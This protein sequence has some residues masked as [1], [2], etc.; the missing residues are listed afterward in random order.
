[1]CRSGGLAMSRLARSD[2]FDPDVVGIYHCT[3]RCVRRC[4]LQGID[5]CTGNN[6]DHRK[7]WIRDRLEFLAGCFGIDCLGYAILSNHLHLILRNRPDVI[8]EWSDA[9]VAKR[10]LMLCPLR[11]DS[12]GSPA[13]PTEAEIDSLCS[14][15][16]KIIELRR[17][18]GDISWMMRM[19]AEPIARR[20]N[21][22]D[23]CSGRF[24]EGRFHAVRLLDAIAVLACSIY[25]DLNP[26]RARTAQTP[27]DSQFCSA[28]D[29]ID[30]RGANGASELASKA[31]WLAPL[32]LDE[33]AEAESGPRL[34]NSGC[35]ASDKG[36]LAMPLD[37][38]LRL[39]DWTGRQTVP[40]KAGVIPS[41]LPSILDRLNLQA[42]GWLKLATQFSR[43]F[44]RVA[45]R[46]ELVAKTRTRNGG[47]RF[48]S[49]PNCPI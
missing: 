37:E 5:K 9:E 19:V 14:D 15:A 16:P 47:H 31:D 24:W 18:L 45:G 2:V 3:N 10:W 11:K 1:M 41:E 4:F 25:V 8:C 21:A 17:R 7:E 28:R 44:G 48:R 6:Y 30:A 42:D 34:S 40:G 22:E 43:L 29:R 32:E 33:R 12:D 13:E 49:F 35:R 46:A 27:E 36:F 23:E 39:L 38:Y 20:S 26:I